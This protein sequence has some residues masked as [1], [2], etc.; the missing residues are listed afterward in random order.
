MSDHYPKRN[1]KSAFDWHIHYVFN[2]SEFMEACQKLKKLDE[3][4][5]DEKMEELSKYYCINRFFV[6]AY[7]MGDMKVELLMKHFLPPI[8]EISTIDSPTFQFIL[9]RLHPHVTQKEL[10]KQWPLIEKAKRELGEKYRYRTPADSRLLYAIFK[11]RQRKATFSE[12][13]HKYQKGEL[14][15]YKNSTTNQ[16]NSEDALEA[17]FQEY[18]PDKTTR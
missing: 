9:L 3:K 6:A 16:F 7:L 4:V 15:Y 1:Y 10:L 8:E 12:I 18:R 13:F 11:E 14:E 5:K 17:Y 2:D